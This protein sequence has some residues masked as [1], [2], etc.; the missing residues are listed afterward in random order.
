MDDHLIPCSVSGCCSI[1]AAW[2]RELRDGVGSCQQ[3]L[4]EESLTVP[5]DTSKPVP[6]AASAAHTAAAV[7]TG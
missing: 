5:Q 1:E 3:P 6:V 4:A 7:G 2:S